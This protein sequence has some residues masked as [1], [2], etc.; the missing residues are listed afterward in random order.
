MARRPTCLL[1]PFPSPTA[2]SHSLHTPFPKNLHVAHQEPQKQ[3]L[4]Y[5]YITV[6]TSPQ[7]AHPICSRRSCHNSFTV[8]LWGSFV[9]CRC[10]VDL[11]TFCYLSSLFFS[12]FFSFLI[13]LPHFSL[14]PLTSFRTFAPSSF[15]PFD[16]CSSKHSHAASRLSFS[17]LRTCPRKQF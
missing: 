7:I 12:F 14:Y 8:S 4:L 17:V 10:I 13:S 15:L 11:R 2:Q 1:G 9:S 5:T 3:R 6:T 16:N